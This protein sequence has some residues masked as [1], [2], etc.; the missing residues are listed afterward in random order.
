MAKNTETFPKITAVGKIKSCN[1]K[2]NCVDLKFDEL[3][4]TGSQFERLSDWID[5]ET[6]LQ[7]TIQQNQGT[8]T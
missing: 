6:D 2:K 8:L 1:K 7:I 3:N 4:F 5:D